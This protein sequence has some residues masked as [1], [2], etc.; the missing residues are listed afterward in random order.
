VLGEVFNQSLVNP[1]EMCGT[2]AVQSTGEPAK[3]M[4]LNT[5]HHAGVSSKTLL[6]AFFA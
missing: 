3:Q 6:L 4:T 5:F 2:L 1:G